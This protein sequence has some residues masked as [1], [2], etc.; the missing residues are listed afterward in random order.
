M[1]LISSE[2]AF[3]ETKVRQDTIET[4]TRFSCEGLAE[5]AVRYK[6]DRSKFML[7]LVA[8]ASVATIAQLEDG[9]RGPLPKDR[10]SRRKEFGARIDR[11]RLSNAYRDIFSFAVGAEDDLTHL[12]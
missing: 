5:L 9:S 4:L 2:P 7:D 8:E 11:L 10:M 3:L 1:T 12:F 6:D